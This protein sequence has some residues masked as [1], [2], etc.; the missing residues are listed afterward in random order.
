MPMHLRKKL[1]KQ[2]KPKSLHFEMMPSHGHLAPG[3]RMNVQVK[4]MPTESV[5]FFYSAPNW[6]FFA[7]RLMYRFCYFFACMQVLGRKE[8]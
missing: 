1:R 6:N 4:F 2:H 5:S 3:Q 8:F 7:T